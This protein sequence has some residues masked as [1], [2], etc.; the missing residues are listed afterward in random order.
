MCYEGSKQGMGT[1]Q[2][3]LNTLNKLTAHMVQKLDE[4]MQ[5][6]QFLVALCN[7]LCREVLTHG[8]TAEFSQMA[9]LPSRSRMLGATT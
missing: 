2:E 8:Y 9:E 1:V 5:Q 4:Y 3:L 6:K 7:P